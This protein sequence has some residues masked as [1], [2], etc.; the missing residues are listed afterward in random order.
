[1]PD[2]VTSTDMPDEV[3]GTAMADEVVDTDVPDEVTDIRQAV[4]AL[5]RASM[6][7]SDAEIIE[8]EKIPDLLAAV[9]IRA[10]SYDVPVT[11]PGRHMNQAQVADLVTEVADEVAEQVKSQFAPILAVAAVTFR[12]L[13]K[14]AEQA[15]VDVRAFLDS[16]ALYMASLDDPPT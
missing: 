8:A 2:E 1:M 10:G 15:G 3:T 12:K 4:F 11:I 5:F 6:E 13:A 16:L 9:D 14:E 7:L